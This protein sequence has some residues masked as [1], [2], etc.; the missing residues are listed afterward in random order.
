MIPKNIFPF[1]FFVFVFLSFAGCQSDHEDV[2]THGHHGAGA[3][4]DFERGPHRGRLLEQGDFS[5]EITIYEQGVAPEFRV[6][7]YE[8]GKPLAPQKIALEIVLV[9]LDGQRDTHHFSAVQDFLRGDSVVTEP[10][11]FDVSVNAVFNGQAMKW[12]YENYEGRVQIAAEMAAKSGI[13]TSIASAGVIS[14]TIALSGR[15]QVDP[16]KLSFARARFPGVVK[17]VFR[18]IGDRVKRGDRLAEIQSNDSLQ[19]YIVNAPVGGVIIGRDIQ[20]GESVNQENL[21]TIVDLSSVWIELDVFEKDLA[22]VAVGQ[23]VS[24]SSLSGELA[25]G[26]ISWLSPM[27]AHASQ[28][29][30]ARVV[31]S[32]R[33][34]RFRPGQFVSAELVVAQHKSPLVVQK[35][36]IQRF[37]DFDVV[38]ARVGDF[39]EVRMLELGRADTQWIEVLEGLKPG[40]QYVSANSYLIKADIEKSGASHDH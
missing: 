27:L 4:E 23:K 37:R 26:K 18:Q 10:H 22:R 15:V 32:N 24:V 16:D 35:S 13:V 2:S 30:Q 12:D 31:I 20:L 7:A 29:I 21:F 5:L 36:A 9:R 39:Y 11:S 1:V 17:K 6:Y 28:S 38:F 8:H 40:T 34:Q 33:K 19:E 25:E 14:E 3:E